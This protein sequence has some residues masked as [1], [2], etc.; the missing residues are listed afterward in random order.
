MID[1]SDAEVRAT[2]IQCG[3]GLARESG[4]SGKATATDTPLSRASP[5]PQGF[6][7][8]A[9]IAGACFTAV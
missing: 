3:S 9:P 8:Q 7:G 4:R 1:G 2:L 6:D 5:L